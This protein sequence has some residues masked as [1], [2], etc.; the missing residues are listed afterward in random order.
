[1]AKTTT[2]QCLEE[3]LLTR[4]FGDGTDR[5]ITIY[6][7]RSSQ[8]LMLV[9]NDAVTGDAFGWATDVKLLCEETVS[10]RKPTHMQLEVA[11]QDL[12]REQDVMNMMMTPTCAVPNPAPDPNATKSKAPPNF[13]VPGEAGVT[14]GWGGMCT[15]THTRMRRRARAAQNCSGQVQ[16]ARRWGGLVC[17][18]GCKQAD[19]LGGAAQYLPC[20]VLGPG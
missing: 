4:F 2:L 9:H 19:L 1:M 3:V 13:Q 7:Q 18:C 8:Y 20:C 15:H 10:P 5:T 17:V 6:T 16:A 11:S 14:A 12:E